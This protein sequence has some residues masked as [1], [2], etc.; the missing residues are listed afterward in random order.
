MHNP[1]SKYKVTQFHNDN[2]G[3]HFHHI[4]LTPQTVLKPFDKVHLP[5]KAMLISIFH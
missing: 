1:T 5:Y 3:H 4:Y 2:H